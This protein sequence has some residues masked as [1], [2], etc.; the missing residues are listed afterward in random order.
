[1]FQDA[2]FQDLLTRKEYQFILDRACA[3]FDPDDPLYQKLTSITYQ[4]LNDNNGF[5]A[6]RSTRHFGPLAFFLTWFKSI[7]NLLLELIETAHID[8][9]NCLLQVKLSKV[10]YAAR[11]KSSYFLQVYGKVHD[12]QYTV[13]SPEGLEALSQ[14]IEADA[15][16]KASLEL[17]LQSYKDVAQQ[18]R[19]REEGIKVAHGL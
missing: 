16:K 5:E 4:H 19:E 14:Y 8:E 2:Y 15:Q 7:D 17:A 10:M 9:I 6:L 1:M 11:F 3:Q 13:E 18:R 12:K